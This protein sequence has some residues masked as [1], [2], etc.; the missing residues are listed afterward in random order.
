MT[1]T[2]A[3]LRG[4]GIGPEIMDAALYVLDA[5]KLGLSYEF[6]DAGMAA[7][8][9]HGDYCLLPQWMPFSAIV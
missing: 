3:V 8:E 9:K 1:Q 7:L 5:M 4:D 6:V 2:I